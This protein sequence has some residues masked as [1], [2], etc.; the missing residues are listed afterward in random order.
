M[1]TSVY[2]SLS[3]VVSP[4]YIV[5]CFTDN[6]MWFAHRHHSVFSI[7]HASSVFLFVVSL[8]CSLLERIDRHRLVFLFVMLLQCSLVK[9]LDRHRLVFLSVMLLQCS[10]VKHL[11]R[12]CLVFLFVVIAVFLSETPRQ[13]SLCFCLLCYCSVP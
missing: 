9:H 1:F 4:I 5:L 11:D 12:H 7:R 2:P 6:F 8:Q 13:T 3:C 10:L